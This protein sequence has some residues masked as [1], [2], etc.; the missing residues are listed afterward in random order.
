[1]KMNRVSQTVLHLVMALGVCV[2][3]AGCHKEGPLEKAGRNVDEATKNVG[4]KIED[5]CEQ[6]KDAAGAKDT[7][8]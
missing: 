2:S 1:M 8:C 7:R 6:A 5:K 3:L 4:N